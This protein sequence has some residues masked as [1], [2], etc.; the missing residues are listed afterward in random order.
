VRVTGLLK[1]AE[2]TTEEEAKD[3]V[4]SEQK[5]AQV[6]QDFV[7]K[8]KALGRERRRVA[9]LERELHPDVATPSSGPSGLRWDD[10]GRI[11]DLVLRGVDAWRRASSPSSS[12]PM[13]ADPDRG[14][15]ERLLDLVRQGVETLRGGPSKTPPPRD[16]PSPEASG[17]KD[18][19][20]LLEL[21]RQGVETFK[22]SSKPPVSPS[23]RPSPSPSPGPADPTLKDAERVLELIL[24][25]VEDWQRR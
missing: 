17:R 20:H 9:E 23:P 25:G 16:S 12:V 19:E 5:L 3:L 2:S 14:D 18:A 13:Q 10:A 15:A 22:D 1:Q 24:R 7:A 21:L 11:A 6:R 8:G 4:R